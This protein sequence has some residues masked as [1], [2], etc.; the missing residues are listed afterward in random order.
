MTTVVNAAHVRI[1]GIPMDIRLNAAERVAP[2]AA[3]GAPMLGV[4]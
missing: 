4:T 3:F 1:Y 2:L